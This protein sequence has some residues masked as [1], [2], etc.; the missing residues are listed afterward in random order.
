MAKRFVVEDLD[1]EKF[2]RVNDCKPITNPVTFIKGGKP[3]P[4]GLL[5]EQ[6][7]GITHAER[8]GI[9]AYIDL[10]GWFLQP[11]A[12]KRLCRLNAKAK[13]VIYGTQTFSIKS[14]ELVED[15]N[16]DTGIKWL[17]ANFDKIKWSNSDSDIAKT[18]MQ[19]LKNLE[20]KGTL[21]IKKYPV[22]PPGYRD[23]TVTT[24]GI[25]IGELNQLYQR[26]LMHTNALK[27]GISSGKP[28]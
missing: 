15:P 14:G 28:K 25:S 5:S 1:I 16:G 27:Q 9:Y 22:I 18:S 17:K 3:T 12:Y 24:K 26:L 4:D 6:I 10:N 20:K 13:A 21:W 19:Y 2:C 23:V 11:L 8:Y 7:F